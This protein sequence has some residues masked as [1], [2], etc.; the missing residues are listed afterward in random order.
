MKS[1]LQHLRFPFSIL[2]LPAFLFSYYFVDIPTPQP[3]TFGLLFFIL[4]FFVYPASNA[5]NSTQDRDE[6]SVGLIKNPL[7]IHNNLLMVTYVF[8]V[9]AIL[10]AVWINGQTAILIAVYIL[11]SRLYSYR[12]IRLKQYPIIGFLTVFI[13]QGA[14]L[15]FIV[16]SAFNPDLCLHASFSNTLLPAFITSLFIGSMYPLSQIYQHEQD[17]R[18]GVKTISAMLGYRNTFLFSGVQ[19]LLASILISYLF[20]KDAHWYA[21]VVYGIFQ[22][23]IILFFLYWFYKVMLNNHEANYTNTMRMNIISALCMNL[24]FIC[25]LLFYKHV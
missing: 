12:K 19:F 10:L 21:L 25:L 20:L 17:K 16:Q 13:C 24:C 5:Y 22:M 14:L 18:D 11:A 1:I 4:H 9:L 7:P 15:F 2:L 23:P 6:G 8:D 3:F